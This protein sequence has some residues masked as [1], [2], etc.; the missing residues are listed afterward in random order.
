VGLAPAAAPADP[1][2]VRFVTERQPS[3]FAS[4]VR[5]LL[6]AD[7]ANNV[8]ATVLLG[9]LQGQHGE[10]PPL[11]AYG[12]DGRDALRA[13]ARSC[14]LFT[15]LANPT[16]NRIYADVGY[17]RFAEWEEHEFEPAGG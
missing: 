14:M 7:P 8:L 1:G 11:F 17:R 15:D 2:R 4:Q 12:A 10:P 9:L 6:D 5:A 13:G 3:R 16:S